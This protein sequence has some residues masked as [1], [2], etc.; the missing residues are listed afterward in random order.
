[1][2]QI[3]EIK[4]L[5]HVPIICDFDAGGHFGA[6]REA[7]YHGFCSL[8]KIGAQ[9]DFIHL[10]ISNPVDSRGVSLFRSSTSTFVT[11]IFISPWPAG[12]ARRERPLSSQVNYTRESKNIKA[13]TL[14]GALG[15]SFRERSVGRR[16][17]TLEQCAR[18]KSVSLKGR[19]V[20]FPAVSS[21][22]LYLLPR[23]TEVKQSLYVG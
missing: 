9:N 22:S 13:L 5:Q 14:F 16:V 6:A 19:F 15:A 2:M 23:L 4:S 18:T 21:S 3:V 1:M 7:S 8:V 20:I 12:R 11:H 17:V 10:S